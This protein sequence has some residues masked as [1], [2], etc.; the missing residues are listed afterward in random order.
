MASIDLHIHSIYSD[1]DTDID[2]IY[3]LI[4]D[5]NI[6]T[7]ALTDHDEIK[8]AKKM[9]KLMEKEKTSL[10]YIPGVELTAKVDHGRMHLLGYEFDLENSELNRAL[11]DK[12]ELDIYN[13]LLQVNLLKR[14]FNISFNS[15]EIDK[16]I[17]KVGNVG[18]VDLAKLLVSNDYAEDID[19]AFKKYLIKI[20]EYSRK[21]KKGFSIEECVRLILEAGGY[22]S[23]AHWP[24][25][26]RNAEELYETSKYLVSLGVTAIEKQH[27]HT[28]SYHRELTEKIIQAFGLLES[29]GTDYHGSTI[30]PNV[31][32]GT[33]INHNVD[34]DSLSL[35]DD[36]KIKRKC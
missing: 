24:S 13:L 1:G 29:G 14:L 2:G 21:D 32:I 12:K 16:I 28:T 6:K 31:R 5:H 25:Y 34:I 11:K 36:I 33:G 22:V 4:K 3:K 35:V 8:G 30:K 17:N 18:R 19:S 10:M 15:E 27:I 26:A 20:M 7:F 9:Q 23:W